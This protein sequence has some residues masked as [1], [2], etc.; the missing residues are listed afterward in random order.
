M[1]SWL[2]DL[3]I[4]FAGVFFGALLAGIVGYLFDRMNARRESEARRA[5]LIR[6]LH[7]QLDMIPYT[8]GTL[9]PDSWMSRSTIH[10]TAVSQLLDG[11][12]LDARKD[13]DLIRLLSVWQSMETRHN[14]AIQLVRQVSLVPSASPE[15]RDKSYN[16]VEDIHRGLREWREHLRKLVP[17]DEIAY[18]NPGDL[19][20][21][22]LTWGSRRSLAERM[23]GPW[24]WLT[25]VHQMGDWRERL[26][27]TIAHDEA[28]REVMARK[29]ADLEEAEK[30]NRDRARAIIEQVIEP[31][32]ESLSDECMNHRCTVQFRRLP[33]KDFDPLNPPRFGPKIASYSSISV[34]MSRLD[35]HSLD[36][37]IIA[38]STPEGPKV[39]LAGRDPWSSQDYQGWACELPGE[40]ESLDG[41]ILLSSILSL[42]Q[43]YLRDNPRP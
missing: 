4:G 37:F 40:A 18:W 30:A 38:V 8:P 31:A 12:T 33:D 20:E 34:N 19:E 35:G 10:V 23:I 26:A 16:D 32:L 5:A 27:E 42:Y 3:S 1:P 17:P 9:T 25:Q 2:S 43:R 15:I 14:D 13:A 7:R 28:A 22:Y 6:A 41:D 36:F 24:K 39:R 21:D 29:Q 11:E